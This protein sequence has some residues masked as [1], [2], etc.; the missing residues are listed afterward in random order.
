[1]VLAYAP[2]ATTLGRQGSKMSEPVPR[3]RYPLWVKLSL[4]G[5]PG[6]RG[7]WACAGLSLAAAIASAVHGLRD[8]RFFYA[9]GGFVVA[10]FLYGSAIRWV[11]RHGSWDV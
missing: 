2:N 6:R 1:V 8:A 9:S 5:V 11:D 4:L 7:V 3:S 10:A